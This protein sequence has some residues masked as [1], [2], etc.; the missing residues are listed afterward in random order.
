[1]MLE[2]LPFVI[3]KMKGLKRSNKSVSCSRELAK[4]STHPL[5]SY[6]ELLTDCKKIFFQGL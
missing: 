4:K 2:N 5:G 3:K 6:Y 1:M